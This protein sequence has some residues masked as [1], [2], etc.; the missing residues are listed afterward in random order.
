MACTVPA[1]LQKKKIMWKSLCAIGLLCV[2]ALALP[3]SIP[4]RPYTKFDPAEHVFYGEVVGYVAQDTCMPVGPV[5]TACER[6]WGLKLQV[7][8]TVSS[9]K[10]VA[11]PQFAEAYSY[12]LGANCGRIPFGEESVRGVPLGSG[13]LVVGR[14]QSGPDTSGTT[15]IDVSGWR[16]AFMIPVPRSVSPSPARA[17]VEDY[18]QPAPMNDNRRNFELRRDMAKLEEAMSDYAR[19]EVLLRLMKHQPFNQPQPDSR[20]TVL[21]ELVERYIGNPD[22]RAEIL[23]ARSELHYF[24]GTLNPAQMDA[25][26]RQRIA[27]KKLEFMFLRG[28][29]L[30]RIA[31]KKA[32]DARE[33]NVRPD[34]AP[35]AESL[36]LLRRAGRA[37]FVMADYWLAQ[38]YEYP[39]GAGAENLRM[40][41][42]ADSQGA[43]GGKVLDR[44]A[45]GD[46][47]AMLLIPAIYADRE[48]RP[49]WKL[50]PASDAELARYACL[51]SR[52][53]PQGFP[54]FLLSRKDRCP[55]A[56]RN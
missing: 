12:G 55:D 33:R 20:T 23:A 32:A 44:A 26:E 46:R 2:P 40:R 3:C 37:G 36:D 19:R 13:F 27:E 25:L 39:C 8:D 22:V 35:S 11:V 9:P 41:K 28:I 50:P 45:N 51:P 16:N 31:M 7:L 24:A 43:L 6:P 53:V 5:G 48:H 42:E 30:E 47:W 54:A 21:E 52:E 38:L 1:F 15:V 49:E 18:S 14:I 10:S 17:A 29:R 34:C 56:G 4:Y